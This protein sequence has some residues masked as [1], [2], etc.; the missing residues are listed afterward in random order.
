MYYDEFIDAVTER[1]ELPRDDAELLAQA[2][3]QTLGEMLDDGEIRK[4]RARLPSA[5]RQ[6]LQ[7]ARYDARCFDAAEFARRVVRRSRLGTADAV[8]ARAAA[9]LSVV[10]DAAASCDVRR[11]QASPD[12]WASP[13]SG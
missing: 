2:V 1:A 13:T 5:L 8:A 4:L 3:L 10:R 11:A 6:D 9:V 7:R 12:V